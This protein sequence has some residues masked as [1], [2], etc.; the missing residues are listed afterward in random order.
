MT[1]GLNGNSAYSNG[2]SFLF[3]A[4]DA[5]IRSLPYWFRMAMPVPRTNVSGL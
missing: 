3:G 1:M 5:K 2:N 4:A